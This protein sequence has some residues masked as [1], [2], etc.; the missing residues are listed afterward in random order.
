MEVV[1]LC[2]G[3]GTRIRDVSELTPKPMLPIGGRPIL[4]HIMKHYGHHGFRRFHLCLGYKGEVIKRYFLDYN[5]LS[6]DFTIGL[7]DRRID[8]HRQGETEDW[9]VS[10]TDT[11]QESM[12]G[13]R[14]KLLRDRIEGDT[15]MTTYGDAVSTV[16]LTALLAFHRSHGKTATVT[17]VHPHGRFGELAFEGHRVT[18]FR[19]KPEN[20]QDYVNGGYFVFNR[21]VF[22]FLGDDPAQTLEGE[23]MAALVEAGELMVFKHDGFWQAMDTQREFA[24][25]NAMMASGQAPWLMWEQGGNGA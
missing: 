5:Y 10:L 17:G 1:I 6:C 3:K 24:L 13:W 15:F 14:I 21:Q 8:I 19:E 11:G 2:G 22:D 18:S 12:T 16:D 23:P 9:T 4:W 7:K 25:L 20:R